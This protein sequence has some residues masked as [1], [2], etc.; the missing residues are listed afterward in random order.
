[1]GCKKV[2][3][4]VF[5]SGWLHRSIALAEI[6]KPPDYNSIAKIMILRMK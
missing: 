3:L 5:A 1:V 2:N 4:L 6:D